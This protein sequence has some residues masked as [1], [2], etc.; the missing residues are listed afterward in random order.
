MTLHF[1]YGSN[2]SR[3]LMAARCQGAAAV[4]IAVLS[5]WRFVINPEGFGSIAP[6]PGGRVHGVLWRLSA[7]DLAAINA[8]ESVDSGLYLRRRLPVR[9][10]EAQAMALVC[11]ARRQGEGTPRPGYIP[12]VVDAAREW[13]LPERYIY[14][15]AR[16]ALARRARQGYRGSG[17]VMR[18]LVI[19]GRVQGV[20]YRAFVEDAALDHGVAGWVR[21]R[22]NGDVEAVF[23]GPPTAVTQLT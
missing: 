7:R 13:Q 23:A 4:G 11:I 14:S 16:W 19:R 20:G 18:H 1:A 5:G 9:C 22:R 21:N 12:L 3:A 10:G 17:S 8:Y 15:L 6:R 2:M